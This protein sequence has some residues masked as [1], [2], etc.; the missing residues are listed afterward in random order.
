MADL[1]Y[2]AITSLDG[3]IEDEDGLFGWAQPDEE[4][5]GFV[6]D[7]ARPVATY[8]YGRRMYETMAYWETVHADASPPP[9]ILDFAGLWQAADKVVYS[10][11]LEETS[12]ARTR[13]EPEFDSDDVRRMKESADGD[14]AI[15]GPGVAALAFEA[16]LIDVLH[17]FVVPYVTGGGKPALPLGVSLALELSD[18]QRFANGTV[19]LRYVPRNRGPG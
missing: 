12:T 4:V 6:N 15:G 14:L 11:T 17:M 13:I 10:R 16:G 19:Y 7:L 5:H 18:E 9:H 2:L 8:L 1:T 3:Y